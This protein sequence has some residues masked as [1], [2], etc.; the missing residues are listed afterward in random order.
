MNPWNSLASH[1]CWIR[2]TRSQWETVSKDKVDGTRRMNLRL[3][4][5]ICVHTHKPTSTHI[6]MFTDKKNLIADET[7][8]VL[9]Q[10]SNMSFVSSCSVTFLCPESFLIPLIF[11]WGGVSRLEFLN[12]P[13]TFKFR[14]STRR[15]WSPTGHILPLVSPA[16]EDTTTISVPRAQSFNDI[17]CNPPTYYQNLPHSPFSFTVLLLS[18]PFSHIWLLCP[19]L[20]QF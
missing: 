13:H 1:P 17:V 7:V 6:P 8:Y 3:T 14:M 4:S 12:F 15:V 20:C 11:F 19:G 16:L 18:F 2:N 10:N 9:L 5:G